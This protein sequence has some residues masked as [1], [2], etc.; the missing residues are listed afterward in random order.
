MRGVTGRLDEEA[1]VGSILEVNLVALLVEVGEGH[2]VGGQ[3]EPGLAVD[4]P[5]VGGRQD[6][7]GVDEGAELLL[8]VS[9][10]GADGRIPDGLG[11][12]QRVLGADGHAG[13]VALLDGNRQTALGLV[14]AVSV[15][16]YLHAIGAGLDDL[17]DLV[18]LGVRDDDLVVGGGHGA[19]V[20]PD[21][22]GDLV[23]QVAAG[24]VLVGDAGDN[25]VVPRERDVGGGDGALGDRNLHLCAAAG[26]GV[27]EGLGV[28]DGLDGVGAGVGEHLDA[29]DL[30][31]D[32][33]DDAQRVAVGVDLLV[34]HGVGVGDGHLGGVEDLG[35][36]VG[37]VGCD[38]GPTVDRGKRVG[39][40]VGGRRHKVVDDVVA[41]GLGVDDGAG[42]VEA[43]SLKR[44]RIH[45]D[46][47]GGGASLRR[48]V[49][50]VERDEGGEPAGGRGLAVDGIEARG[51]V[52]AGELP[53]DVLRD[54]IGLRD[55]VGLDGEVEALLLALVVAS[56]GTGDDHVVVAGVHE[57]SSR[58]LLAVLRVVLDGELGHVELGVAD[59]EGEAVVGAEV[60][61]VA[62]CLGGQLPLA[63]VE[64]IGGVGGAVRIICVHL[65]E[66]RV[67][68]L[69]SL[70]GE[71]GALVHPDDRPVGRLDDG[72]DGVLANLAG[73]GLGGELASVV[74]RLAVDGPA[75][76]V[77]VA[78]SGVVALLGA[79]GLGVA[80]L[81]DD[82]VGHLEPGVTI[83]GAE[84]L[85]LGRDQALGLA[86]GDEDVALLAGALELDDGAVLSGGGVDGRLELDVAAHRSRVSQ[87][88]HRGRADGEDADE[89]RGDGATGPAP[90]VVGASCH[91]LSPFK[92][93]GAGRRAGGAE[94]DGRRSPGRPRER[95]RRQ[96]AEK[97]GR[98]G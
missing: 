44:G 26:D 98:E 85:D 22:D 16:D 76:R 79:R 11:P 75:L 41:H 5:L 57:A 50:V 78:D 71:R 9:A 8:D 29:A 7:A 58:N 39:A 72:E 17:V 52:A 84:G 66:G 38:A 25:L 47:D 69:G 34:G 88:D 62:S 37:V 93:D 51:G 35:L 42:V 95:G 4:R 82:P 77:D 96:H 3:V 12:V 15:G 90:P 65:V 21:G 14:D 1:V 36:V 20:G 91:V 45:V 31:G 32:G 56:G 67:R 92:G 43:S 49:R 24:E 54:D 10:A 2:L 83:G 68:E 23:E 33:V 59:L 60:L 46:S 27:A 81:E 70:D 53:R 94:V 40:V 87:R 73:K 28:E 74:E 64:G 18:A 63:R 61:E 97:R 13:E 48:D 55:V 89:R 80:E 6:I 30:V 19:V 86:V